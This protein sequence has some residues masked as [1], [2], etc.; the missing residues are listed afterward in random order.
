MYNRLPERVR[1][2]AR[3]AYRQFATNPTHPGLNFEHI[4]GT[5]API[6]SARVSE[7]YRV[8]GRKEDGDT[9]VWFWIGTHNEYEKLI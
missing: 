3:T 8:S 4:Q 5:R 9:I 6:Y 2:Q 1:Q 7:Q